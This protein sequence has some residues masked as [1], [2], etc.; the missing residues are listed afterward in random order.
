M[1]TCSKCHQTKSYDQFFRGNRKDGYTSQCKECQ[2]EHRQQPEIKERIK[3]RHHDYFQVH[4]GKYQEANKRWRDT[5]KEWRLQYGREW[6]KNHKKEVSE[7]RKR[8]YY[9]KKYGLTL[10]EREKMILAQDSLC[11]LCLRPLSSLPS[12][13]H[14][15]HDH[16]N[17]VVRGILCG[18]C[19]YKMSGVDDEE[20]LVKAIEYRDK[21]RKVDNQPVV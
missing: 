4:R 12:F 18:S 19:N 16:L 11:R 20:W 3:K 17:N 5:H 9:K 21:Y 7:A 2:R 15:D 6:T 8:C 10:G 1:K 13:T 14:V